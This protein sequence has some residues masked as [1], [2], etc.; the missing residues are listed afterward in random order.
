MA[1]RLSLEYGA[2]HGPGWFRGLSREEQI[3]VL[4][5]ERVRNERARQ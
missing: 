5:Y 3:E 4:A 1:V 2:G